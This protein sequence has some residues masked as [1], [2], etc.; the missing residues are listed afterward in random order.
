[1]INDIIV[2]INLLYVILVFAIAMIIIK[3][4]STLWINVFEIMLSAYFTVI[5]EEMRSM[6]EYSHGVS[7]SY[8]MCRNKCDISRYII[9]KFI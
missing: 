9:P 8:Y 6:K 5:Y 2:N 7:S 3:I 4:E 1:M